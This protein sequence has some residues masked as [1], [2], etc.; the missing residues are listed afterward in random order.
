MVKGFAGPLDGRDGKRNHKLQYLKI[1]LTSQL[2]RVVLM[3]SIVCRDKLPLIKIEPCLIDQMKL[4][5]MADLNSDISELMPYL[6]RFIKGA[7][8]NNNNQTLTLRISGKFD[9]SIRHQN[10]SH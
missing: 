5:V 4:R 9:N 10:H 2:G 3:D 8:Y 6:N 1:D 7:I